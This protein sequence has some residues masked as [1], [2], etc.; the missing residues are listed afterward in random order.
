MFAKCVTIVKRPSS[1]I[2]LFV[3]SVVI[4]RVSHVARSI[5]P[6]KVWRAFQRRRNGIFLVNHVLKQN[7]FENL[8]K[9]QEI[10]CYQLVW[11]QSMP[12]IIYTK[13]SNMSWRFGS[14]VQY[15]NFRILWYLSRILKILSDILVRNKMNQQK[16]LS[17]KLDSWPKTSSFT[18]K[19]FSIQAS[20]S[21]L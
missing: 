12:F 9:S 2:I 1:I 4:S 17:G 8:T 3:F 11:S 20:H 14:L 16:G 18:S 21:W 5:L 19:I 13:Y 15:I 7:D 10:V 6:S